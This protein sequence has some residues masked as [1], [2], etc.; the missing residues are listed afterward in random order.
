MFEMIE[1][2][3][4]SMKALNTGKATFSLAMSGEFDEEVK[5]WEDNFTHRGNIMDTNTKKLTSLKNSNELFY[6]HPRI[7]NEIKDMIKKSD[8]YKEFKK[9]IKGNRFIMNTRVLGT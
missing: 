1:E 8:S 6:R 3:E 5:C 4:S 7:K 2:S 9:T